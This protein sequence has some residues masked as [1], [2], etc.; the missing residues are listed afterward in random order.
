MECSN[1]SSLRRNF[2]WLGDGGR[3]GQFQLGQ[4][5]L[6]QFQH[7]DRILWRYVWEAVDEFIQGRLVLEKIKKCLNRHPGASKHQRTTQAT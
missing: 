1:I 7:R 4:F 3:L 2:S 6:G 5:Q